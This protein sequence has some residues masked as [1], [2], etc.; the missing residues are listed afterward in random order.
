ADTGEAQHVLDGH[1][2]EVYCAAFSPDGGQV[3]TGSADKTALIW[4][5][6]TGVALRRLTGHIDR[7]L[8]VQYNADGTRIATGSD[9]DARIWDSATGA[10]VSLLAGHAFGI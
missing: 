2:R 1:A 4:D 5:V 3:V 9:S 6:G 10:E 8:D 7:I